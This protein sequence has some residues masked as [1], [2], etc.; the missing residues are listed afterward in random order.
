MRKRKKKLQPDNMRMTAEARIDM[1]AAPAEGQPASRPAIAIKAYN[2]DAFRPMFR[3]SDAPV[4]VDLDGVKAAEPIAILLDHFDSLIVGQSTAVHITG[5][6][7]GGIDVEAIIT[8][9][10]DNPDDPAGKVV[11]HA[12][13]GFTWKASIGLEATSLERVESGESVKVNGRVFNGPVY[14]VRAGILN[15]VS[16]LSIG[17]DKTASAKVAAKS[18]KENDMDG[19]HEWLTAQG[20]DPTDL[21]DKQRDSLLKLYQTDEKLQ[22]ASKKA[23]DEKTPMPSLDDVVAPHKVRRERQERIKATVAKWLNDYPEQLDVIEAA[24]RK[25]MAEDQTPE[26]LELELYREVRAHPVD[27]R[28]RSRGNDRSLDA[29][30]VEA[31]L[32]LAGNLPSPEKHFD[33]RT[34]DAA[35]RKW[36]HGLGLGELLLTAAKANGYD[37]LSHRNVSALLEAA[38]PPG[39][40]LR[41]AGP[42]TFDVS[43]ILSNVANKFIVNYF[44]SVDNAWQA[45]AKRRPVS[46]FK[47]VTT[48][49][50]TGDFTY[51]K[52]APGG[53]LKH[54]SI[55][56]QTYT[57][58]ADTR[59]R[60]FAID[61]RDIVNDDLGA[62]MQVAQRLGRGGALS[63]NDVFWTAFLDNST[64]FTNPRGNYDEGAE[65]ALSLS[66]LELAETLFMTQ[67]DPDG[68]PMAIIPRILLVP[69][70]L[71]RTALR[72]MNS[73][74]VREL[75]TA[76]DTSRS[77]GT[78]NTFAGDFRVV[79]SP[80]MQTSA[81]AGYSA[82]AWYLLASP[83][84]LPVIEVCF[85]N[86]VERP[87]VE[88]A[89]A[90]FNT[91]GIQMR[92][93][94]DFGVAKQE[95]RG[96]VKM[97]G[98][99]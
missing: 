48:Y 16:L 35:S 74:E 79:S 73:T 45:I 98:E 47:Q 96:G 4:V 56:E 95:Y 52:V 57:N 55:G 99:S 10:T 62:F 64:F 80:Y 40:R 31:G 3:Y 25:A 53:E 14:I 68:K 6:A 23:S 50:L 97:K 29:K 37:G 27:N 84:D 66:A 26:M 65:T 91:L 30:V 49:S 18:A 58:Q 43:G 63:L 5:G 33:D 19:F 9:D 1:Q 2:G 85:L 83:D 88:S 89:Q 12:R 24:G 60:M 70:S 22:A 32:C 51:A 81:Y 78:N 86:G 13:N 38:F 54:G 71:K 46:D 61:R 44:N 92:G 34:L 39:G 87:T 59:G 72:L 90:D 76:S 94:F 41:A 69:S 11:L 8:G 28:L 7:S 36:R 17:A 42:S 21:E 75:E 77:Y 93:F 20:F 15:E 67:T 82:L